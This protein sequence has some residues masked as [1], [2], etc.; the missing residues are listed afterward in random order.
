MTVVGAPLAAGFFPAET[1]A[2]LRQFDP[3]GDGVARLF[4]RR[5]LEELGPRFL[6]R[7]A[8]YVRANVALDWVFTEGWRLEAYAAASRNET[9]TGQRNVASRRRLFQGL[10]VEPTGS[11]C[12]DPSGGCVPLNLFGP[13]TLTSAA[14]D[15]IRIDAVSDRKSARQRAASAT[16]SGEVPGPAGAV[17]VAAGLEWR[18]DKTSL[19]S[20]A[21]LASGD[22]LGFAPAPAVD[23]AL[24]TR[25]AFAEVLA[26]VIAGRPWADLLEVQA[27]IRL[28]DTQLSDP[29]WTWG[30]GALWSVGDHW[31]L[32]ASAQRALRAPNAGELFTEP[33]LFTRGRPG[34]DDFC[35]AVNDP[36]GRGLADTCVA[37][38]M[39]RSAVGVY[40]APRRLIVDGVA[41]G[42]PDLRAEVGRT[43]T[44]GLS[45]QRSEP[46]NLRASVDV[47]R[48]VL[49]GAIT[50]VDPL[51]ACS[52][53]L[54]R[55]DACRQ[56]TRDPS[57]RI[58]FLVEAPINVSER[59]IEGADFSMSLAAPAPDGLPRA[60]AAQV[61][62]SVQATTYFKNGVKVEPNSPFF[63]CVG[64]F[65]CVDTGLGVT[66]PRTIVV[67]TARYALPSASIDLRWRWI[68][69]MDNALPMF[70]AKTNLPPPRLA[71]PSVGAE[72]YLDLSIG[73]RLKPE[74]N[75]RLG[76][77]NL[78]DNHPPL[79][80]S[81]QGQSNTDPNRYGVLGRQFFLTLTYALR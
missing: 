43:Y 12:R 10:D 65:G 47:F 39:A 59:R 31:T 71:I 34:A 17:G 3:D 26:P 22:V 36:V 41:G 20:D 30:L 75:L 24:N 46:V 14:V 55:S 45:Y 5:R 69:G 1:A 38:G 21:T 28:S 18:R 37:Q 25:E 63:D 6:D 32:R 78:F 52:D 61:A 62:V 80:G 9:R 70:F 77:N 74:A 16:V 2:V 64:L 54:G 33:A 15:F 29:V 79:L 42:N 49:K 67:A 27:S 11:A 23:G 58:R 72:Q 19:R 7:R 66:L 76:V 13:D 35:S 60:D 40:A 8:E 53:A 68:A 51:F 57:G 44:I 4:L 56:T 81:A 48:I 50:N 73:F